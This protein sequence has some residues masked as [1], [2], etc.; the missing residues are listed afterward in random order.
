MS[1]QAKIKRKETIV[2]SCKYCF[3]MIQG[4]ERSVDARMRLH[5]KTCQ[6]T[7]SIAGTDLEDTYLQ[8]RTS[9]LAEATKAHDEK[10]H[11]ER[12]R[13]G[14]TVPLGNGLY[15]QVVIDQK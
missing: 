7:K 8:Y 6:M 15:R 13:H 9:L 4:P 12:K 11:E 2:G 10:I 3:Y 5:K 1:S 14:G